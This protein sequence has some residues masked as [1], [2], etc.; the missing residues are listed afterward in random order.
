VSA[1]RTLYVVGPAHVFDMDAEGHVVY[2]DA[3]ALD[4]SWEQ[5]EQM[6]WSAVRDDEN[7]ARCTQGCVAAD[8]RSPALKRCAGPEPPSRP[9]RSR[10]E[11]RHGC[12]TRVAGWSSPLACS[13]SR[14]RPMPSRRQRPPAGGAQYASTAS[15][16]IHARGTGPQ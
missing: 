13:R 12:A 3:M 10:R 6:E 2:D 4:G 14:V 7:R 11:L 16:T 15:P 9:L 5:L 8:P 1:C